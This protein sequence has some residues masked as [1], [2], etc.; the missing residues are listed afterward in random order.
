MVAPGP[1]AA[2]L[3]VA[4]CERDAVALPTIPSV[5]HNNRAR[6]SARVIPWSPKQ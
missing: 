6:P 4:H 1:T 2:R 3:L 5:E